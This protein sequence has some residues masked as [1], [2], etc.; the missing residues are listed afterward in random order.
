MVTVRVS[1]C[2][3]SETPGYGF[4]RGF[5][6]KHLQKHATEHVGA[7]DE[8]VL[9]DGVHGLNLGILNDGRDLQLLDAKAHRHQLG[10]ST[11]RLLSLAKIFR[12]NTTPD[13]SPPSL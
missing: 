8:L 13:R 6:A 10:C 2:G 5:T 11:Q 1:G 3:E 12:K 4:H 7:P 9:D